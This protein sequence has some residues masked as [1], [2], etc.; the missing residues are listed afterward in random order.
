MDFPLKQD[1]KPKQQIGR[2][3]QDIDEIWFVRPVVVIVKKDK[4]AKTSPRFTETRRKNIQEKSKNV[5]YGGND[6][7]DNKKNRRWNSGRNLEINIPFGLRKWSTIVIKGP[8]GSMNVLF[9]IA[10]GSFTGYYRFL[11][12]F[13]GSAH[14]PT[15]LREKIV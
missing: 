1:A 11:K 4:T 5:K 2:P 14:I 6:V 10:G 9:A 3:N 13:Y 12:G 8:Y 7:T 15:I